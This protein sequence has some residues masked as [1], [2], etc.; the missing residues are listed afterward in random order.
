MCVTELPQLTGW[1]SR[2]KYIIY[3]W[4]KKE[5]KKLNGSINDNRLEEVSSDFIKELNIHKPEITIIK[6][7][8]VKFNLVQISI[9]NKLSTP[10]C[11]KNLE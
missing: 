5:K 11:I 4:I 2:N 10:L 1:D 8:I 6:I 3:I 9:I 7:A